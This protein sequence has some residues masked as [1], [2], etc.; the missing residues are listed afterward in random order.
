MSHRAK[1]VFSTKDTVVAGSI[2]DDQA[3]KKLSSKIHPSGTNEQ[4]KKKKKQRPR[5]IRSRIRS[6]KNKKLK[7]CGK[8]LNKIQEKYPTLVSGLLALNIFFK[9]LCYWLDM[10]SDVAL[11]VNLS[12]STNGY[13]QMMYYFMLGFL[14]LQFGLGWFGINVYFML[15]ISSNNFNLNQNYIFYAFLILFPIF[16][17]PVFFS[18]LQKIYNF[19]VLNNNFRGPKS[20]F[21]NNVNPNNNMKFIDDFNV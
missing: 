8:C 19:L 9:I 10:S 17:Y 6:Y 11:L 18:L 2:L 20:A 14:T 12:K 5:R 15:L 1:F 13:V 21:L 16:I 3:K 7:S 4:N